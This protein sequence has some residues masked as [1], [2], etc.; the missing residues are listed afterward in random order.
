MFIQINDRC[1]TGAASK[2]RN[3]IKGTEKHVFYSPLIT[4]NQGLYCFASTVVISASTRQYIPD[5]THIP[6]RTDGVVSFNCSKIGPAVS[7]KVYTIA[8]I[9]KITNSHFKRF[10]C[11]LLIGLASYFFLKFV[12][13]F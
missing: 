13:P 6:A 4:K 7:R 11:F 5:I 12:Y 1:N 3:T 9:I 2:C 8:P 10:F